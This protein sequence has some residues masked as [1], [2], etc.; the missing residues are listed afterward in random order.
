MLLTIFCNIPTKLN[1]EYVS[2]YIVQKVMFNQCL[3]ICVY[4]FSIISGGYLASCYTWV[5]EFLVFIPILM[6]QITQGE[7]RTIE[8][9]LF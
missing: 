1:I 7:F 9:P 4:M 3:C 5:M 8:F 2:K 6:Y